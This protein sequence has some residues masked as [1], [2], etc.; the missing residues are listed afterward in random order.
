MYASAIKS[1]NAGIV[2]R[3]IYLTFSI[4]ILAGYSYNH[5]NTDFL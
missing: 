3:D 5:K 4:C 2:W 1:E